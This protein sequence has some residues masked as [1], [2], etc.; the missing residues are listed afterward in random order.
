VQKTRRDRKSRKVSIGQ[1]GRP[2][3]ETLSIGDRP[4]CQ[5]TRDNAGQVSGGVVFPKLSKLL[6]Q[7]DALGAPC[8]EVICALRRRALTGRRNVADRLSRSLLWHIT[9]GYTES[10]CGQALMLSRRWAADARTERKRC[11]AKQGRRCKTALTCGAWSYS[12]T[13]LGSRPERRRFIW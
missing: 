6:N 13:D 1:T 12:S 8:Y 7:E 10:S 5:S 2:S 9:V 4:V 11:K 3:A